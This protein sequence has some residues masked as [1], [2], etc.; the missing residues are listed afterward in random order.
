MAGP[1]TWR[2]I[3]TGGAGG[4]ASLLTAGQQ[5]VQQG[6]NVLQNLFKE[7]ATEDRANQEAVR[8]FNTQQYLDQVA[9]TDLATLAT[10]EGQAALNQQRSNYG[11]GI[12]QA[13]T[14]NAIEQRLAAGQQAAI[15]QG[16]F[17]DFSTERDQRA[18]VDNIRGLAAG[19]N[20][21]EANKILDDTAFLN[22]GG[23]RKEVSGVQDN[24]R[25]RELRET[26]EGRAVR[27]EARSAASH[28]LSMETGRENLS[29]SK[30]MHGESVRKINE[31]RAADSI[32][33]REFDASKQ[34][35]AMQQTLIRE[36]AAANDLEVKDDGTIDMTETTDEQKNTIA[37]QLEDSGAG[38]QSVTAQRQRIV[39]E[40][41]AAGLGAAATQAALARFDTV[42]TFD[43]LA[44]EDQAKLTTEIN[45]ATRP[46]RDTEARL[47]ETFN[48]KSKDN[49]YMSP[50][51]DTVGDT[52]KLVDVMS[53][54]FDGEWLT[55][56]IAR[57][58]IAAKVTDLLQNGI[59]LKLDGKDFT[60]VVPP[61]LIERAMDDTG[62]NKVFKEG[63]DIQEALETFI[64]NNK[65]IQRQ[66]KESVELTQQ[67]QKDM[68]KI[69][70]E[71]FKVENSLTQARK[72]QKGV[73]VSNNDWVDNLI[74]RRNRS[75]N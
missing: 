14:R 65:G 64:K 71:K 6:F 10:P 67:F 49:P 3:Q 5:Q 46:M 60:G 68:A 45:T 74:D 47:T 8:N 9:A 26:A 13:G 58:N 43:S 27:G 1:I 25:Q 29:Y 66:M 34:D 54:K 20:F 17:D 55:T 19:G 33:F 70:T 22:E 35:N 53:K 21:A 44:T 69:S 12:D 72:K 52:N 32:A 39:E 24:L 40:S 42:R 18:L 62:A 16:K 15:N 23:L 4:A 38:G 2:S 73:T 30:L 31:D 63:G 28:A 51:N 37:K 75:G 57:D 48:R 61:S 56:D 59:S 7:N 11:I 36:I 41:R 50:S